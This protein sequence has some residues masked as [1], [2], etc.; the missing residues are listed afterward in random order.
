M[1]EVTKESL[2]D[3]VNRD[4]IPI[5]RSISP[6]IANA[7]TEV[8]EVIEVQCALEVVNLTGAA[9]TTTLEHAG[10]YLRVSHTA[11][12][13]L[14]IPPFSS[15]AYDVGTVLPFVQAGAGQLTIVASAGVTIH[16]PSLLTL[17]TA[18]QYSA[19]YLVNVA[20]DEW[21]CIGDMDLA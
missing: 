10:K 9:N 2:L 5:V 13:Q 17:R 7:I 3:F 11:A 6:G 15:V 16:V 12:T 19:G 8:T 4:L 1:R 20:Q 14:T 18:E 21:D